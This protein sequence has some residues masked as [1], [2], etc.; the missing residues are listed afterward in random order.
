MGETKSVEATRQVRHAAPARPGHRAAAAPGLAG[1]D[2]LGNAAMA[3]LLASGSIRR[4]L[5]I[6]TPSD[7]DERDADRFADQVIARSRGAT[8]ALAPPERAPHMQ[9]ACACAPEHRC[10]ECEAADRDQTVHRRVDDGGTAARPH[11]AD[12]SL[13][14]DRLGAGDPLDA[15][16]RS[17]F[18]PLVGR[19]LGDVR[20]HTSSGA[21]A[22][23]RSLGA[24]AFAIGPDL[25]FAPGEW[26]T[27][28]EPGQRLLAHELA[29]VAQTDGVVR[30][31][32]VAS[33]PNAAMSTPAAMSPAPVVKAPPVL[34]TPTVVNAPDAPNAT[35]SAAPG[36]ATTTS[37]P[38]PMSAAPAAGDQPRMSSVP[39]DAIVWR[40]A[41][42]RPTRAD[43]RR[44][45]AMA[46]KEDGPYGPFHLEGELRQMLAHQ[47]GNPMTGSVRDVP[48]TGSAMTD[49]G[50][51]AIEALIPLLHE[52]ALV[53]HKEHEQFK[54]LVRAATQLRLKA[55]Q[56]A[57]GLW[58]DFIDS[59]I[60]ALQV[61]G[62]L[63]SRA[64][65]HYAARAFHHPDPVRAYDALHTMVATRSIALQRTEAEVLNET[66]HG[67][68][69]FCHTLQYETNVVASLREQDKSSLSILEQLDA[70]EAGSPP[71]F[72]S[73][74]EETS[75]Q[76]WLG[77]GAQRDPVLARAIDE[78]NRIQP[79]LKALGPEGYKVLELDDEALLDMSPD[80]LRRYVITSV[81]DR[82]AHFAKA[83]EKAS[84]ADFDYL[85]PQVVVEELLQL[86]D[87]ALQ[88]VV[89]ADMKKRA[90][91]AKKKAR[92]LLI[93][94][95]FSLL[96][97][98]FPP[99]AGLGLA[100]G[101]A[102]AAVGFAESYQTYQQGVLLGHMVGAPNIIT[103]QQ[104]KAAAEM[105]AMGILGMVLSALGVAAPV[106]GEALKILR[107]VRAPGAAARIQTIEAEAAGQRVLIEGL[108]SAQ[109]IAT[110]RSGGGAPTRIIL[111]GEPGGGAGP[112]AKAALYLPSRGV[113]AAA[114][115]LTAA[116]TASAIEGRLLLLDELGRPITLS[117]APG[118]A[119]VAEMDT[120]FA[121]QTR[122]FGP[123]GEALG[124][125]RAW[126]PLVD[127][128]G[129]PLPQS[130][131]LGPFAMYPEPGV[132]AFGNRF[133][134]QSPSAQIFGEG[135][136]AAR[137]TPLVTQRGLFPL[138]AT[139]F[140]PQGQR[141]QALIRTGTF[142]QQ[143][144]AVGA[145]LV[146]VPG[147]TGPTELRA[148]S[149]LATDVIGEGEAI[150]HA[151]TPQTR[152]LW[153][154]Q[155]IGGASLRG[156]FPFSHVNDAE[157][158]LLERIRQGLP[159]GA[160]GRI[161][162]LSMR[163][164][165]GGTVLE[166]LPM[167]ASCTQAAFQYLGDFPDVHIIVHSATY[168]PLGNVPIP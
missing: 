77:S 82:L 127:E 14:V 93:L 39:A 122:L 56:R 81:D 18:E 22:T 11:D 166:P 59:Q 57:L 90:D 51:A 97:T 124:Q 110:A 101:A 126:Q 91:D 9:P 130:P 67:G 20:I 161:H 63:A 103:E 73:G 155:R 136:A 7:P 71:W 72:V 137:I 31:Q 123:A 60:G 34:S 42:F 118:G 13:V 113:H 95:L 152:T 83:L 162:L 149:A 151:T 150:A 114:T 79:Y 102:T 157:I 15:G 85:I 68:C 50:A 88:V 41:M 44:A 2:G 168:A 4:K 142:P 115:D 133:M 69:Q 33:D 138:L 28:T 3:R 40:G 75:P 35:T 145:A 160:A 135:V 12:A 154:A 84:E 80:A 100:L 158:K 76:A 89:R 64:V 148:F 46:I 6:G 92:G 140:G 132:P 131:R 52:E 153:T 165:V 87:P 86:Q 107:V 159:P 78:A 62:Q 19:S 141:L 144:R 164:R 116:Q 47:F 24:R 128:F 66:I 74:E 117:Q 29:H 94:G 112:S 54:A 25:A 121:G 8:T 21:A 10:S 16:T 105:R 108:D 5:Q 30:R 43:A 65:K 163:T 45:L 58:R 27:A 111:P 17:T 48:A 109:P 70:A 53:L 96:L 104:M 23:A 147:Y 49:E 129:T 36:G 139:D 119:L 125:P 37:A 106:G 1:V 143:T 134:P 156:E 120:A 146:Q 98:I 55:N 61:Q 38:A 99:T 167:C 32:P 26:T